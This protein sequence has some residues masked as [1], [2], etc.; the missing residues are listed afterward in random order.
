MKNLTENQQLIVESLVAEFTNINESRVLQKAGN[1]PLLAYTDEV[2]NVSNAEEEERNIIEAKNNA[3]I[4]SRQEKI[5]SDYDYLV[6]LLEEVDADIMIEKQHN[7]IKISVENI[8]LY[9]NYD[10]KSADWKAFQYQRSVTIFSEVV[11]TKYKGRY[12]D[13]ILDLIKSD[14]FAKS[15]KQLINRAI[16]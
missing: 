4:R 3:I 13:N 9:I 6:N 16:R 5:K 8:E 14:D 15:F 11:L 1:N 12:Y 10:L 7:G 2:Y